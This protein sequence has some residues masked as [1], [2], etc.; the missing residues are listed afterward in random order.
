MT[1]AVH[2]FAVSP[3][4]IDTYGSSPCVLDIYSDGKRQLNHWF[5]GAVNLAQCKMSKVSLGDT[6]IVQGGHQAARYRPNTTKSDWTCS[7]PSCTWPCMGPQLSSH[8][9]HT[10]F[11][12]PKN[13]AKC[14]SLQNLPQIAGTQLPWRENLP[15]A[16]WWETVVN[17]T[18]YHLQALN[19]QKVLTGS[20]RHSH[21]LFYITVFV[22]SYASWCLGWFHLVGAACGFVT[23]V[24]RQGTSPCKGQVQSQYCSDKRLTSRYKL[25]PK[26]ASHFGRKQHL[27][28]KQI[29]HILM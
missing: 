20:S 1:I 13:A 15:T 7:V 22:C 10:Q 8:A 3:A 14:R 4:S 28:Y 24:I 27:R 19:R 12:I 6:M 26:Y 5:Y 25:P 17:G 2:S 11:I 29:W 21:Q 9:M 18:C 16:W 23:M